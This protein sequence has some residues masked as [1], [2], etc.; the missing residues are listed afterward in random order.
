M[1]KPSIE[2][3][4]TFI[5]NKYKS[6]D[7]L[8]RFQKEG[9]V[10]FELSDFPNTRECVAFMFG[11]PLDEI[12]KKWLDIYDQLEKDVKLFL[13]KSD[14]FEIDIYDEKILKPKP[15]TQALKPVILKTKAYILK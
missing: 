15:P 6:G 7:I 10:P 8:F 11:L 13:E 3:I 1:I 2:G 4:N 9:K 14:L 12:G 5:K